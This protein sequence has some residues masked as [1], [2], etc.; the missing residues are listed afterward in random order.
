MM[1][2]TEVHSTLGAFVV[3]GLEPEETEEVQRHLA[4]CS[5]CKNE[6]EELEKITHALEAALPAIEPPSH[7]KD[8]ILS[9][10][11]AERLS[12]SKETSSPIHE[13]RF[14]SLRVVLPGVAAAVLVTMVALGIFFSF[15]PRSPVATVQLYPT[16]ENEDYWGVANLYSQPLGNQQVELKLNDVD[17]P[18]PGS[19]YEAWFTSGKS[20]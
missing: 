14:K 10:V 6:F 9:R 15:Q 19:F 17:E 8:E 3:G 13:F 18:S 11:R 7:L 1:R 5:R 2:C 20:T 16:E 4:F 12:S